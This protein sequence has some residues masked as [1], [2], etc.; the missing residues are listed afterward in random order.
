MNRE[1]PENQA[2]PR[3]GH[4]LKWSQVARHMHSSGEDEHRLV[5]AGRARW[6][7]DAAEQVKWGAGWAEKEAHSRRK[8]QVKPRCHLVPLSPLEVPFSAIYGGF[9][10][11][12]KFSQIRYFRS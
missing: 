11:V 10:P 4:Q 7:P 1:R 3:D 12:R 2:E 8:W 5:C 9:F 6:V